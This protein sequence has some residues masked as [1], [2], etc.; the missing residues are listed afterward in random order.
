M[1]PTFEETIVLWC[2]EKIDPRLPAHVNKTF[3]HQMTRHTTLKD[4]QILIFQRIGGMIQDLDDV[5][6]NRAFTLNFMY[7]ENQ[8]DQP[9]HV[10][11]LAFRPQQFQGGHQTSRLYGSTGFQ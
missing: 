10:E 6:A 5:E 4:L 2:L 9:D 7:A 8:P 1:S 3:G 11:L